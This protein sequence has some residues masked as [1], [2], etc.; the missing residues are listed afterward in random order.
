MTSL[1]AGILALAVV[2]MATGNLSGK[3]AMA[4]NGAIAAQSVALSA[5]S[6]SLN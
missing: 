6:Q 1:N 4:S 5:A 2:P 3:M